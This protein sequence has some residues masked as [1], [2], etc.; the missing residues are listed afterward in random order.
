MLLASSA[1]ARKMNMMDW[2]NPDSQVIWNEL[3]QEDK[4]LSVTDVINPDNE[5]RGGGMAFMGMA[6]GMLGSMG[7]TMTAN[8]DSASA[9]RDKVEG[10]SET[11]EDDKYAKL[12]KEREDQRTAEAKEL[13]KEVVPCMDQEITKPEY[14][15]IKKIGMMN[16][17][18]MCNIK[19]GMILE[20]KKPQN[21]D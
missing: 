18:I 2:M 13:A 21:A 9:T 7:K 8:H 10:N 11:K 3:S 14:K 1:W 17:L 19:Y 4:L 6:A 12:R 16:I 20:A 15:G 5:S